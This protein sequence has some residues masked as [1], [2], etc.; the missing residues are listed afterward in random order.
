MTAVLF[1]A[2]AFALGLFIGALV[3]V[4]RDYS[5][6]Q[7]AND[8]YRDELVK[9]WREGYAHGWTTGRVRLVEEQRSQ[10]THPT[11]HPLAEVRR[12]LDQQDGD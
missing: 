11:R 2:A 3:S 1:V 9:Q 5:T 8:A 10:S 4:A 7:D 6:E 12:L